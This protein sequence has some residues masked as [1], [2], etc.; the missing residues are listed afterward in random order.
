MLFRSVTLLEFLMTDNKDHFRWGAERRL[1]FIEFCIYWEGAVNR[2]DIMAHFNVSTPQASADLS[3]YQ[4]NAPDNIFYDS[5]LKK[6]VATPN[7]YPQFL[8]PNAERYL[9]QLRGIADGIIEQED[10]W[11][12]H[13]PNSDA[14]VIPQKKVEPNIL[15]GLLTAVRKEQ[16]VEILYQSMNPQCPEP[17]WRRITPH[18]FGFDGIRWHVRA[19]CHLG[20][21]FKDFVLS[22]CYGTKDHEVAGALANRDSRWNTFFEVIIEP[23]QKLSEGHKRAV[24]ID[25]C[26]HDGR[27]V[28]P[29]RQALL[30]YF[31][32][33]MRFDLGTNDLGHGNIVVANRSDYDLALIEV[34]D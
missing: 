16:S 14:M 29:I 1:E 33:R 34:T 17:V 11:I 18:A 20:N 19:F 6:Y 30:F 24:A 15:K 21:K 5:S 31:D 25:Y 9:A 3:L 27:L 26:M 8:K 32:K 23:N 10:T 4:K 12:H 13:V 22:R 7:F 28:L 2:A